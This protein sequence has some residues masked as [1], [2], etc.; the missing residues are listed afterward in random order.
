MPIPGDLKKNGRG[1]AFYE[2]V[3]GDFDLKA[4]EAELLAETARMLDLLDALRDA[5]K[6]GP[7]ITDSRG[8]LVVHP[9]LVE[10]RQ[11]REA[12]RKS[13]HALGLPDEAG[14][15]ARTRTARAAAQARWG[16]T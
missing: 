2:T 12:V 15:T 16:T 10:A 6:D 14:D 1:R 13:F 9:A 3:V 8:N 7:M 5:A 4:D 11:V